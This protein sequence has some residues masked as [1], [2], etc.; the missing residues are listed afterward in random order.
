[1]LQPEDIHLCQP[2]PGMSCGACCGLYNYRDSSREA[3]AHRLEQRTS[4]FRKKVRDRRDLEPFASR[5]QSIESQEK[6]YEVIYC[7]E[8][9]GYLDETRRRVGCLLHPFQNGGT[10][11]RDVSFYGR[12]LC[13]G[14]FCPSYHFLTRAEQ[15]AVVNALDDWY[16]YGLVITDIDL[17]KEYFRFIAE[18]LGEM[19]DPE[20]LARGPLHDLV[21]R[22]FS[23]KVTWPFRSPDTN[24][25]GKYYFDGSQYMI[26]HIDYDALGCERSRFDTIFLSLTSC[27]GSLDELRRAEN[28]IEEHLDAF[29]SCYRSRVVETCL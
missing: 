15:R 16:L 8:Y 12:D 18:G 11:L 2:G 4:L 28:L 14:H 29:I 6:R 19:P 13:D 26:S 27:F 24:R 3:L 5:I 20:G 23:F 7:C 17:V 21:R 22:F 9:L 1:M 25:L 10:D